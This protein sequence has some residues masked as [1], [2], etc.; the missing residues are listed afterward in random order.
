MYI[1]NYK[2]ITLNSA[3]AS[4]NSRSSLIA[5][6]SKNIGT[7]H[8]TTE[9]NVCTQYFKSKLQFG[10]EECHMFNV[11]GIRTYIIRGI[12]NFQRTYICMAVGYGNKK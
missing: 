2:C 11:Y 4:N 9:K 6:K 1:I 8:P 10:F 7:S 5:R 12:K 3:A